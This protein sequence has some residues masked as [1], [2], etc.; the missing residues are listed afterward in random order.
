MKIALFAI[1]TSLLLSVSVIGQQPEQRAN[2]DLADDVAINAGTFELFTDW[3]IDKHGRVKVFVINSSNK[4]VK[5]DYGYGNPKLFLEAKNENSVWDRATVHYDETCGTGLGVYELQPGNFSVGQFS[6][7]PD[8]D[9]ERGR[10]QI[11]I[12]K[13]R[14]LMARARMTKEAFDAKLTEVHQLEK[15]LV[16][17]SKN[18]A[19]RE[20]RIRTF[21]PDENSIGVSNSSN[22]QVDLRAIEN[23]KRDSMAIRTASLE[24][25]EAIITGTE[26]VKLLES[27]GIA[28]NPI[29]LAI[30]SVGRA[31][32]SIEHATAILERVVAE[33]KNETVV[34]LAK[35]RLSRKPFK[36]RQK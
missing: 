26:V 28:M 4:P 27:G 14:D 21:G 16:E 31:G 17:N 18:W 8:N 29:H 7:A 12:K 20:I 10:I 19:K 35:N 6:L 25:L 2:S 36:T 5:L 9:A 33:S 11:K 23:S 24:R 15:Q 3:K 22:R 32:H 1:L 13:I 34:N 30:Y